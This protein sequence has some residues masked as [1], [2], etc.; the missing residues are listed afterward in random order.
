MNAQ[1]PGNGAIPLDTLRWCPLLDSIPNCISVAAPP[2]LAY[3]QRAVAAFDELTRLAAYICQTKMALLSFMDGKQHWLQS[4]LGISTPDT[5]AYVAFCTYAILQPEICECELMLVRDTLSDKRFASHTLVKSDPKIRFYA[6]VPLITPEGVMVGVLSALDDVPQDLSREQQEALAT[7][8]RQA[9]AQLQLRKNLTNLE[10]IIINQQQTEAAL[11]EKEARFQLGLAASYTS[12]VDFNLVTGQVIDTTGSDNLE[13]LLG[14]VP[15][16]FDGTQEAFLNCVH[17][18]DRELVA[19]AIAA[20]IEN[21]TDHE[22]E[23]RIVCPDG[24]VRWIAGKGKVL[25]SETATAVRTIGTVMDITK[26][27]QPKDALHRVAAEN[28]KLAQAV[29]TVSDGV[30][31][32]DPHQPDCPIVYANPAFTRITGYQPDEVIGHNCRFLQ[33]ADTD[34]EAIAKIRNAIAQAKEVKVT[35]LNY[36]KDGQPFWNQLKISPVF[37]DKGDLLYLV[38]IQTDITLAKRAETALLNSKT[39]LQLL[40]SIS[41]KTRSGLSIEQIIERT[42]KQISEYFPHLRV[43][44]STINPQGILMVISSIEPPGMPKLS[45][46]AID[47]T[48]ASEYLNALQ[49][50]ESFICNDVTQ[51]FRLTPL[52]DALLTGQTQSMLDIPL[53][54][55][56]QLIGLL[57]FDSPQPYKWNEHEIATLV[58][59]AGYLTITIKDAHTQQQRLRAESALSESLKEVA[60]IKFALDQSSIVVVTDR[61][62]KINYVNDKF[63]EISQ[64]SREE[65]LGQ[66]HRIINSGHHPKEF[67]QQM[68]ATISSGS[69]W[70]GEIRNRAKDGTCYWVDTTIVPVLNSDQ[71]PVE[72]VA[73]RQ[74]ITERKWAE[75]L[76]RQSQQRFRALA[77]VIPQQVWTAQPDGALDYVNQRVLEYFRRTFEEMVGWGWQD[78]LHPEDVPDCIARWSHSLS[79][80]EPYEVEFRLL[81]VTEGSYRWHLGRAVPVHDNEGKIVSWFGTNTDIDD[82]KR[83]EEERIQLLAREQ[84]A[85]E[86][87]VN[88]ENRTRNI[89][90]SITDAFFTLDTEWRFTYLNSRAEQLLFRSKDELIDRCIWD[91]FPET[92]SSN[93]YHEYHRAVANQVTVHFEVFYEPLESWFEVRGYPYQDGLSVYFRDVTGRKQSEAALMERS[94]LST[95]E[96]EVGTAL[97]AAG[98]LSESLN[99]CTEAMV[100]HLDATFACIWTFNQKLNRLELQATTRVDSQREFYWEDLLAQRHQVLDGSLIGF[101]A[102]TRQPYLTQDSNYRSGGGLEA[103]LYNDFVAESCLRIPESYLATYP[104]IVEDRLVGVMA[105]CNSQRFSEAVHQALGWVVNAIAIAIDRSW[106]KEALSARREALLFRLASQ[107]RD[108]LDLDTILGTAVNEIRCLLQVD[109]CQYLWC[110][111]QSNQASLTVTHE[112]TTD[113]SRPSLLSE[114]PPEEL[115]PLSE[116]IRQL[117]TLRVDDL[118]SDRRLSAE[119]GMQSL[120]PLLSNLGVRSVLLLPLKTH[121]GHLGAIVCSHSSGSR[122]WLDSEIELLQGVVDQLAIAIDQAELYA[123][124]RAAARAAQTQTQQLEQALHNLK[125]AQSQLIQ[126][127]KMSSLGQMVAGIAHEINNPVNF[128]TGNLSHTSDYIQDLLDLV[129]LYQQHYT[130]PV[131]AIQTQEEEIDLDFI[132]DD[133]PKM[134]SSMQMGADRIRQIVLSLRNFS[135]LDEAEMKPVDIHEGIDNSLLILHSRLKPNGAYGGIQVLKE[136]GDLPLV[137]CY[138]GQLNQVFMNIL[139]NAI[140]ALDSQPEPKKITISTEI[141]NRQQVTGNGEETRS[142]NTPLTPITNDRP[143][144][145]QNQIVVIRIRDNGPGMSEDVIKRL[146]D[147]FFTT[148]PVGKGTGLGLS[149]SYQIVVEKHGGML[150]CLSEPGQG[151]EFSIEIPWIPSL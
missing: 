24:G 74:D 130:N 85:R 7:L 138:A 23:F 9:I 143:P 78:V 82:H 29:K 136:Y 83:Q 142:P 140:D 87:A 104:L 40:N 111:A 58:D 28:L 51:D 128:I 21:K 119:D 118:T 14:L 73:I 42:L 117:Q 71:Q 101:V 69:V 41:T 75:E 135:R 102:Q 44:Y 57:C 88:S 19:G 47:L 86:A 5:D 139:S 59:M 27:Q 6:G 97:G 98:S 76:Q 99:R 90:E 15:G 129:H 121:A 146:F 50:G 31:I 68:W 144:M 64:Y 137:D 106:A 94:R 13:R 33:G 81:N 100:E 37:S 80:G 55:S 36:R 84:A 131:S 148:K 52:A 16:T 38:G 145:T 63:C 115:D 11:C 61:T 122:P 25:Y 105:I 113:A 8:G 133:L 108:S 96:A 48:V 150:K 45:G 132:I 134:L 30:V 32:V 49:M 112:A 103:R 149:I 17:P 4:K 110:W 72:Y 2:E 60:D 127:E 93:F 116:K 124:S 91:E 70:H 109:R 26:R 3:L 12:L 65:L 1:I 35:L 89:L 123:Q 120:V 125:Q 95:L 141:R 43:A 22:I 126:T 54:H 53:Q 114:C 67:F 10:Q 39:R 66:N 151:A 147:P 34:P 92:A 107:I 20:S 46:L 62:G 18:E 77:E 79:T 56:D